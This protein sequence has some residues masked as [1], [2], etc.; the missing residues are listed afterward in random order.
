MLMLP[1]VSFFAPREMQK[2]KEVA[3]KN[4]LD[5]FHHSHNSFNQQEKQSSAAAAEIE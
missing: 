1:V 2:R 4:C 3:V 5:L